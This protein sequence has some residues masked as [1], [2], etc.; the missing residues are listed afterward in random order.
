MRATVAMGLALFAVGCGAGNQCELEP[1]GI[2]YVR[3][4]DSIIIVRSGDKAGVYSTPGRVIKQGDSAA[5]GNCAKLTDGTY[6]YAIPN[7]SPAQTCSFTVSG[8]Q[9]GDETITP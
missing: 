3:C 2:Q 4:Y 8:E 7:S 9:I 5:V 6:N 1:V